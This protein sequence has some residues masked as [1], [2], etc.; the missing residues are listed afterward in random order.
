MEKLAPFLFALDATNYSRWLPVHIHNMKYLPNAIK[1]EFKN[2]LWTVTRS[3]KKFS[4][5]AID[6]AHEQ[7]NKILKGTGGALVIMKRRL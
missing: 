2:G 6:Q 1:T 4:S 7:T 3:A 5:I